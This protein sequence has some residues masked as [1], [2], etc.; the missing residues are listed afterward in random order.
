MGLRNSRLPAVPALL[1]ALAAL[2]GSPDAALARGP[3]ALIVEGPQGEVASRDASLTF[4]ASSG[5]PFSRFE[6]RLDG[7]AWSAC[8]SPKTYTGLVGGP[9]RFEVR[10]LGLLVDTTPAVRDWVVALGTQTLPC[11][12]ARRCPNPL[13]PQHP[14]PRTPRRRDAEGCAYGGN[15][16]GEVSSVRLN[17]AV[18]CVLSKT[19]AQRG[20]PA[21]KRSRALE[22]AAAGHGRDMVA[23]RY[24]SHISLDGK[25]PA[26][27]IGG[28]GY[29]RGARFWAVGEV[30]AFTRASFTPSRIVRAWLRSPKHRSVILTAAFRQVG[31]GIVRGTPTNPRRGAT[32]VANLG[33]RG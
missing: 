22:A 16:V 25:D 20:L 1:W 10:L 3:H 17:R 4:A 21:L 28:V 31:V 13:P 5:A 23:K 32:C 27:R 6:C 29:L 26:D 12:L 15:R 8:S 11:G 19:R 7:G 30:M 33:R 24:Y 18:A 14:H 2:L 9:H